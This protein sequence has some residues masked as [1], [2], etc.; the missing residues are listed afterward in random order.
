MERSFSNDFAYAIECLKRGAS[1]VLATIVEVQGSAYRRAGAHILMASD[2]TKCG[3]VSAGCLEA[4]LA[5]RLNFNDVPDHP[6][7][8]RYNSGADDI[9]ELN[10]GC[11][12]SIT[13]LVEHYKHESINPVWAHNY[14]SSS[15]KFCSLATICD[16]ADPAL[17]GERLFFDGHEFSG[18]HNTNLASVR[19]SMQ[20][21]CVE[22]LA[23]RQP[24]SKHFSQDELL[25]RVFCDVIRP[26]LHLYI[27][28]TGDDVLPLVNFAKALDM[29]PHVVGW[30]MRAKI[31]EP[32][33]HYIRWQQPFC[34]DISHENSAFVVMSHNYEMDRQFLGDLSRLPVRYIGV[35]GP[36]R[37]TERMIEELEASTGFDLSKQA[38][39]HYPIG[40][41]LGADTPAEIALS[42]LAEIQAVFTQSQAGFLKAKDG[43]IHPGAQASR[44]L[45]LDGA[46]MSPVQE[47]TARPGCPVSSS[48]HEH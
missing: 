40:L 16:A 25:Y 3:T 33:S 19:E 24:V 18:F 23:G 12:G 41:D 34:L 29:V 17:I 1:L 21:L 13:L 28:G 38:Q 4:D 36:K 42:I 14:A 11:E 46:Q 20:A 44:L 39:L 22:T 7:I 48:G 37:R 45:L 43:P 9:F 32:D 2:G 31:L 35:M 47:H 5:K 6:Q 10:L 26:A 8:I 27:F 30:K 15:G